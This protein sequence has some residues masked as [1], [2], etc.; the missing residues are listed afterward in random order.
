METIGELVGLE[1]DKK[2]R[3]AV[4][5]SE[6]K[7]V[8]EYN[9]LLKN[10]KKFLDVYKRTYGAV[11]KVH[12]AIKND[13][14]FDSNELEKSVREIIT[15]LYEN[16]NIFLFLNG[17]DEKKGFLESHSVVV[18]FYALIIGI[19]L[20]YPIDKLL[21]LGLGTLL[22]DTG[23]LKVPPY[24]IHKQSNLTEQEYQ[25]VKTHPLHGYR[26]LK[27]QVKE[28]IA[29]V[30]LQHHERFDGKGYPRGIKGNTIS[31]YA[32]I[33]AIAD[34]YEAQISNRSYKEKVDSYHAMKNLLSIG[35]NRFDPVILQAFLTR[36]SVYPIGS[37]VELNNGSTGIVI[38]SLP[39]KPLR[40]IVKL[41]FDEHRKRVTETVII[42]L[43]EKTSLYVSGAL[44]SSALSIDIFDV[45]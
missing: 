42:N 28:S 21:E 4:S 14:Q 26:L 37:L 18:A 5:K 10:R 27:Q 3:S 6:E 2:E 43:P 39:E 33:A 23:M 31:E 44:N 38:G 17:L 25:A 7:I 19:S 15:L 22:I 13:E 35:I 40:P 20:N 34:S 9:N 32:R 11:K 12:G 45:L 29:N 8:A 16:H 30:S 24:I 1:K 36:M 41:I